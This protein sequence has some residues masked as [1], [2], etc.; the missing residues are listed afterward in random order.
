[1]VPVVLAYNVPM[2]ILLPFALFPITVSVL[3]Q[4]LGTG[5]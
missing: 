5:R 3:A 1:M 2:A 4:R